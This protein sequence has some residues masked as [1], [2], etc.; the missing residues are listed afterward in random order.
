[1]IDDPEHIQKVGIHGAAIN[2]SEK[3]VLR[4][5]VILAF[6]MPASRF[7]K[8]FDHRFH[9]DSFITVRSFI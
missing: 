6:K 8:I 9:G 4:A 5:T 1:M 7:D 3:K 2:R